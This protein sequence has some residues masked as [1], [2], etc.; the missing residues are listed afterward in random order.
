M[1]TLYHGSPILLERLEPRNMHGDPDLNEA[2]FASPSLSM[3][4]TYARKWNDSSIHQT[5]HHRE[6]RELITL[7]EMAPGSLSL[8]QGEGYLYHVP[9]DTF[10]DG[11]RKNWHE[12][13]SYEPVVPTKVER[14]SDVLEELKKNSEVRLVEYDP[15]SREMAAAMRRA[16]RRVVKRAK[17][18]APEKRRLY[19]KWRL[20][21][22]TPEVA[23]MLKEEPR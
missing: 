22:A 7:M 13:M 9:G 8:F 10:S 6:G 18:M 20:E 4:L 2:V 19:M 1:S 23:R 16:M 11:P 17:K 3:A 5:A 14:F 12:R 15:N 21:S